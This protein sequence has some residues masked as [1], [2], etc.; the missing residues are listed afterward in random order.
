MKEEAEKIA[1]AGGRSGIIWHFTAG[2]V[3]KIK[4]G[5]LA[6]FYAKLIEAVDPLDRIRAVIELFGGPTVSRLSAHDLEAP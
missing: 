6:G 3:V 5:P 1:K 4:N 2:D